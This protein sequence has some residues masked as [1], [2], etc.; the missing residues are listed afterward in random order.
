M[1][2]FFKSVRKHI[3]KLDAVHLREQYSRISD[4]L[5]FSEMIF[6]TTS[7]GY[8]TL[9]Q[10]GE[11]GWSNPAAER[12]LGMKLK[13]ILP[14]LSLPL[15]KASKRE[16]SVT[17]PEVRT[18]E[19][20]TIPMNG[21]TLVKVMDVTAARKRSL[22]ELRAGASTAVRN[23]AGAVAHEIGN[24]L[25]AISL[26]LQLLE[27]QLPGD[28]SVKDCISQIKRLDGILKG[29]LQAL[30]PSR[31]NLAPDS[32]ALPLTST[33]STL[34]TQFEERSITVDFKTPSALPLAA[35]D[36]SQME[37]VFFNLLKNSIEAMKSGG[38]INLDV[39]YDDNNVIVRIRD[40][41]AGM[42][43]ETISHLF[44][45]YRTGKE[46]GNGL[47]LMISQRIIHDHGGTIEVESE[48]G[49][50]TEFTIRIPR[51]EKRVR[52]LK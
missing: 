49:S 18:L 26:N 24:P 12:L 2:D 21:E 8:F 16:I 48:T 31:P 10:K 36:P 33:L 25:N 17:Y 7:D 50:G 34:K 52:Q 14:A 30:K 5:S 4:E 6:N 37:Q 38:R 43:N 27:R 35:I 20:Q 51:I 45:P 23:L 28:E 42:D 15:A 22:E 11:P 32:V 1:K 46:H 41:G 3:G 29:F 40:N 9:N 44:E 47:G 39:S 19:V 13:D